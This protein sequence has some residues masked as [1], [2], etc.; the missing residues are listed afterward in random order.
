MTAV[1]NVPL[2]DKPG[3]EPMRLSKA[4]AGAEYRLVKDEKA[5]W[6]DVHLKGYRACQE[7]SAVQHE[8]GGAFGPRRQ[9]KKRRRSPGSP[10]LELCQ[11][12]AQLW[13]TRDEED[14]SG[15]RR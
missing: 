8:T 5:K 13:K 12:H 10:A 3:E 11:Q 9:I 14:S 7:C 2:F 1:R 15:K 4:L 6:T